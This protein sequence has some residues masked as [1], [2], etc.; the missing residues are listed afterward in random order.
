VRLRARANPTTQEIAMS[1]ETM[2]DETLKQD[3]A[4]KP[5]GKGG[6][7]IVVAVVLSL[8]LLVVFNMK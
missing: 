6:V 4:P 7:M 1:D 5:R 2:S 8:V 3:S